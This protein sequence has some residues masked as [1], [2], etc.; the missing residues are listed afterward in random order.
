MLSKNLKTIS[1]LLIFLVL[2]A[3]NSFSDPA[4]NFYSQQAME[5][6][7]Q[8]PQNARTLGMSGSSIQTSAD[9]SSIL[10]NPAGLGR[11]NLFEFSLSGGQEDRKG[12][13]IFEGGRFEEFENKLQGYLA[14]PIGPES[15]LGTKWGTLALGLSRY[16]GST[17]D[18]INS[19][20][21]GH[22]RSIAYGV[23]PLE[24]FSLGYSLTFVED[25][26]HS[27][28]AD[29]HST[30]RFM[31]LVGAQLVANENLVFGA[32]VGWLIGQ[33]D[34]EEFSV[35][36]D[37]LSKARQQRVSIGAEYS[38]EN[39][40]VTASMNFD[41]YKSKGNVDPVSP[42]IIV[43]NREEGETLDGRIGL[44]QRALS[45]LSLRIGYRYTNVLEYEFKRTDLEELSGK[46]DYSAYS[47]G[48][49]FH[50][51]KGD[52]KDRIDYFRVDY[53]GEYRDLTNG[54]YTQMLTL[55]IPFDI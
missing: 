31:H 7:A 8:L 48:I 19:S 40:I 14:M 17:S 13:E 20:P 11:M 5:R 45:W 24:N 3:G 52:P 49:G 21:D 29:F 28:L 32:T 53:G 34:F 41:R 9:S 50:Y 47:G 18:S 39:T 51:V 25:Q 1:K 42:L 43:G 22:L 27:N 15:A 38:I 46:Y 23:A 2:F 26:L 35:M 36:S 4:R 33:T 12:E 16:Q 55:V 30:N 44:E 6:F 10:G 54:D 37:G